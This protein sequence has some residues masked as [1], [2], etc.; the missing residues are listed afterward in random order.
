MKPTVKSPVPVKAP[1]PSILRS[2][3]AAKAMATELRAQYKRWNLPMLSW[4]DG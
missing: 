1:H 3:A 4:K 2:Q